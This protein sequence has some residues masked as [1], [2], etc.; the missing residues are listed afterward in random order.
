MHCVHVVPGS[1]KTSFVVSGFTDLPT[2]V[3]FKNMFVRKISSRLWF[4]CFVV[5]IY[6]LLDKKGANEASKSIRA[7]FR[8]LFVLSLQPKTTSFRYRNH[9]DIAVFPPTFCVKSRKI[10]FLCKVCTVHFKVVIFDLKTFFS[11]VDMGFTI[12]KRLAGAL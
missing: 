5:H 7:A 11:H 3:I 6:F 10:D 12:E 4:F 8:K 1:A 2:K 9:F